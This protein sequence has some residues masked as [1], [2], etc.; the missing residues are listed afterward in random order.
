MHYWHHKGSFLTRLWKIF[1]RVYTNEKV[2]MAHSLIYWN[3]F[4]YLSSLRFSFGK[5]C[6]FK[7]TKTLRIQK[8][9]FVRLSF[10]RKCFLSTKNSFYKYLT[11]F[12]YKSYIIFKNI[13]YSWIRVNGGPW[14]SFSSF[15][16]FF[17]I[18]NSTLWNST[19]VSMSVKNR[20][21]AKINQFTCVLHVPH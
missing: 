2:K 16:F 15:Y 1:L 7:R 18:S 5:I 13:I 21:L 17:N 10:H 14:L 8:L 4:V 20:C 6:N 19:F 3:S 12:K 9:K 11:I